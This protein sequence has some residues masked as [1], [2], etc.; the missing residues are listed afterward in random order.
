MRCTLLSLLLL[1]TCPISAGF[2]DGCSRV[3]EWFIWSKK[4]YA[5]NIEVP[6][7]V[8]DREQ[9]ATLLADRSVPPEQK[10]RQELAD[11]SLYLVFQ[12]HDHSFHPYGGVI[13]FK[14]DGHFVFKTPAYD[15]GD[16]RTGRNEYYVI[17]LGHAYLADKEGMPTITHKWTQ[18]YVE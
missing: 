5:K 18:L 9:V 16:V 4:S 12:L 2:S 10:T 14:V 3:I 13:K 11:K 7:Y 8:L 6:A 17:P 1:T 15:A